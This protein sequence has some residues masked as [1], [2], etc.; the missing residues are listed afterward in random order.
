MNNT[1][2]T[3]LLYCNYYGNNLLSD[4]IFINFAL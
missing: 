2:F 1:C 3:L 4:Y